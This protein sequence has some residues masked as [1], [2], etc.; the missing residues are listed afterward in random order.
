MP[1]RDI[2][3]ISRHVVMNTARSYGYWDIE[4]VF[5]QA[6]AMYLRK[7]KDVQKATRMLRMMT[8]GV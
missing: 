4:E 3:S 6:D 8:G 1:N 2:I 5:M 7:F